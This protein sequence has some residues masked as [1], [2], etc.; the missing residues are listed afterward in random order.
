MKEPKLKASNEGLQ[1]IKR[2]RI[3]RLRQEKSKMLTTCRI[4]KH[5]RHNQEKQPGNHRSTRIF[6]TLI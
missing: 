5:K 1:S 3:S 2:E 4:Q 6:K